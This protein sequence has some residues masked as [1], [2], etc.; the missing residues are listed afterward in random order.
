MLSKIQ[1]INVGKV[2]SE[3]VMLKGAQKKMIVVKTADSKLFEEA[4]FVMRKDTLSS[5]DD[6]VGEA[7]RIIDSCAPKKKERNGSRISLPLVA[8][9]AFMGGSVFGGAIA[10]LVVF[11]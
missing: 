7:N 1:K 11:V 3:G 6:M 5:S 9:G 2:K 8:L 4:Y 10:L